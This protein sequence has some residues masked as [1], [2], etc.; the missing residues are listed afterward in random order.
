VEAES[1]PRVTGRA[2]DR[3][4]VVDKSVAQREALAAQLERAGCFACCTS[5]VVE[6]VRLVSEAAEQGTPYGVAFIGLELEESIKFIEALDASGARSA[7][8]IVLMTSI[9]RYAKVQRIEG[10]GFA[11]YL[12]KPVRT[13][14]LLGCLKGYD[15]PVSAASRG[16]APVVSPIN[17]TASNVIPRRVLVVEDN[18]VNQKI[19]QRFLER[20]GC[21]VVVA[22]NGAEGVEILRSE[23]YDLVLMDLQ[24][25]VMG[26]LEAARAIRAT[27]PEGART[28]IV[29]LTAH[30]MSGEMERC[31][32]AGMDDFLTKPLLFER[33]QQTID[34]YLQPLTSEPARTARVAH[35]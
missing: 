19:A 16:E 6:A 35:S 10:L 8:R 26:G 1:S 34:K 12:S 23:R 3:A 27:E 11:G 15:S 18:A 22:N 32:D 30:A 25:P 14:D 28:P 17:R 33:L 2:G 21:D 7:T 4:L 24:M 9:D 31:L 29:A 5:G 20:L 13:R